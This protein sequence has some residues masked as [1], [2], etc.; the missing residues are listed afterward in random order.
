M[1]A[2][3]RWLGRRRNV[4]IASLLA[5]NSFF[6]QSLRVVCVP[7]MNCYMCPLSVFACPI[8]VM[9]QMSTVVAVPLLALGIVGLVAAGAGR[10]ACGWICPFGL[11]QE[12]IYKLRAP[13]LSLPKAL[14]FAR[15][16]VLAVFVFA[17]PLYYQAKE[18]PLYFCSWCPVG[19][20][21][22]AI[23]DGL[24][25][26]GMGLKPV[27]AFLNASPAQF[28]MA[29]DAFSV[30][31][32]MWVKWGLL[33]V[34]LLSA[35]MVKR[36]F[37]R[38]ICPLGALFSLFGRFSWLQLKVNRERCRACNACKKVCPVDLE[39]STEAGSAECITCL[40]CWT[41]LKC[42]GIKPSV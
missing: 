30:G 16:A 7:A 20:L 8:G 17:V 4:Q 24:A 11:M 34:V 21:E 22:A 40:D 29:V 1:R 25:K 27:A 19:T 26:A 42:G 14:R 6:L 2:M 37:C 13:K 31:P 36:P 28:R 32:M 33:A 12:W 9:V 41:E 35:A 3:V 15:Y 10:F 38:A 18:H 23:P 39:P 5:M